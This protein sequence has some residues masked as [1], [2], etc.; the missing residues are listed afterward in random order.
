MPGWGW[1]DHVSV[2][3]E[4][5]VAG[6]GTDRWPVAIV[7]ADCARSVCIPGSVGLRRMVAAAVGTE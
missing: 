6:G 4:L 2:V 3:N 7:G 1:G 5:M